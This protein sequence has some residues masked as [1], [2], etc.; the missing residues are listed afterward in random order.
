MAYV[1][2]VINQKGGVGKTT[3]AAAVAAGLEERG[4][5]SLLVDLDA[6]CN[7][8]YTVGA[9][10]SGA[11]VL[12][13]LLKEVS[14]ADAI[15]R[16]EDENHLYS[17]DII[18]GSKSLA[19]ADRF[20]TETGKEYRLKEALDTIADR[21][22]YIIIDTPPALGI[23]TVNALTASDS[24]IIPI[25][26]DVF[27]LNGVSQLMETME[28]V[29]KYCNPKLTVEGLLLTRF[30]SRSVLSKE[31]AE[32]A[33]DMAEKMGTKLFKAK[34]REAV[35]VREAQISRQTLNDYAPGAKVT[36]DYKELVWEIMR[37]RCTHE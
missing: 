24:V 8:S 32:M 1:I 20:I 13:V 17:V 28:P 27:S 26:A 16:N 4:A 7:L 15:Q 5:K 2:S 3:T 18:A 23:L 37:E 21:Y 22:E 36:L 34:I 25:Q 6:Q 35:A 11:T 30:S 31:I 33:A 29:K 12:G 19:G 10:T 9:D 14:A